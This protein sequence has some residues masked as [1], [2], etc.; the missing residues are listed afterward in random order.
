[1]NQAIID[2]LP[3]L[4]AKF[5]EDW[6]KTSFTSQPYSVEYEMGKKFCRI[7]QTGSQR[8]AMGFIQM[9]DDKIF[10]A[11]TLLKAASWKAPAVN[12]SRGSIFDL[13]NARI[14]WM[15]IN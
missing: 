3:A 13:D 15:G 1:M 7:V 11:G 5:F 2:L 9:V 12:F 6:N 4:T 10:K 14:R 8:S